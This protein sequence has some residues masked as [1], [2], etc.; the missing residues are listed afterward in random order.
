[1][2]EPRPS[3]MCVNLEPGTSLLSSIRL[4]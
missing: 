2:L 3:G 1:L 4:A